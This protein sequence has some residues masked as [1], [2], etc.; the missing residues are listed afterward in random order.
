MRRIIGGEALELRLETDYEKEARAAREMVEKLW[1]KYGGY[2]LPAG[3][4][5][6]LLDEELKEVLLGEELSRMREGR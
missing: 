1:R 2:A 6:T 3:E 4:L 5:R